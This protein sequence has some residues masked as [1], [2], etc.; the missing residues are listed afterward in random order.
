[1]SEGRAGS[2]RP[3]LPL[4]V[5]A[6]RLRLPL[7]DAATAAALRAGDRRPEWH[8]DFPRRDELDVLGLW[9][10][11][12]TWGRR[13]VLSRRAGRVMGSIGFF[14]PPEEAADGVAEVEVGFGLVEPARGHGAMGEALGALLVEVDGRA[15]RVR[16][17]VR[18][19]NRAAL[20]VL[21][22]QGFTGLRAADEDG[23]LVMV[24][25]LPRRSPD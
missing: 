9:V 14:A 11:G 4:I 1:M 13:S 6:E 18:P 8:P 17:R 23:C 15:V 7:W 22:R 16:A 2:A 3:G 10:D 24:R 5:E 20:R 12:D 21:Q 19:E 25:P